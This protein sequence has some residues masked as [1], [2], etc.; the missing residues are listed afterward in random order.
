M[1]VAVVVVLGLA[2]FAAPAAHGEEDPGAYLTDARGRHVD[3]VAGGLSS[4]AARIVLRRSAD[5][6]LNNYKEFA[7]FGYRWSAPESESFDFTE[8]HEALHKP[9]REV[10]GG[11]WRDLTGAL[12]FDVLA[13]L[14]ELR[15]KEGE[16]FTLVGGKL[17]EVGG[18]VAT[19]EN[20]PRAL[21]EMEFVK[22]KA[23]MTYGY[24]AGKAGLAVSS[25]EISVGETRHVRIEYRVFRKVSGFLLPTVLGL[26]SKQNVT[27]YGIEYRTVNGNVAVIEA[28]SEDEVKELVAAFEK[29]WKELD[30]DGKVEALRRFAETESDLVSTTIARLGLRDRTPAVRAAAA[31]ALGVM[32]RA[33]VVPAL[34]VAMKKNEQEQ[35]VYQR[36]IQSLGEIGDPRAVPALS[37]GWWNQR[38]GERG[39]T[40]ARAKI[41]ALGN[42]RHRESVDALVDAFYMTKDETIAQLAAD[43]ILAMQKLTGQDFGGDRK[44]WKDWWKRNRS[45]H[46]F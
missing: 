33:N 25:R 22:S 34:L 21:F 4:F 2:V 35:E 28:L 24:E 23:K 44:A 38:T 40:M 18:I 41:R 15:M 5:A 10:L 3:H 12:W 45:S 17:A 14:E 27:E 7:H 19:F 6:N 36:L 1:R 9:L 37:K 16:S 46:R 20:G 11:I 30:A 39:V 29:G 8:T 31:E 32:K 13:K 42:I 43:L 26:T